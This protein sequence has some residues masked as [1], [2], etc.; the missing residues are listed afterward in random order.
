[1]LKNR[2]IILYT[3]FFFSGF[4]A[5]VFETV[6]QRQM[7]HVFGASGPAST[8]I[9]TSFFLGIAFGSKL[10]GKLLNRVQSTMRVYACIEIWIAIWG[11]MVPALLGWIEPL[12]IKLFQ[13]TDPGFAL[14]LTY[15]YL[16]AIMVIMP[17]TLG[18]GATLPFMNRLLTDLKGQVGKGVSLAYGINTIGSVLGTLFTGFVFLR[19]LGI[20]NSLFLASSI[21]QAC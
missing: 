15:R 12:Y 2:S 13:V 16:M 4:S 8:A 21:P 14:S 18:M 11:L 17:A 5:L 9:L 3:L 6:W 10:G 7:V 20:Q 19:F 1:M